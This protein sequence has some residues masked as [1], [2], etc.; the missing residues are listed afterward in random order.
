MV[1]LDKFL[2]N[3]K[4]KA[5]VIIISGNNKYQFKHIQFVVL[6]LLW[7]LLSINCS[8]YLISRMGLRWK[9]QWLTQ[10]KF[11]N[12]L[13]SFFSIFWLYHLVF[14]SFLFSIT[15]I[16]DIEVKP[17]SNALHLTIEASAITSWLICRN[18][19]AVGSNTC[20]NL[21]SWV[22]FSFISF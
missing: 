1:V 19:L 13:C 16:F 14:L 18:I 9:T 17:F 4:L 5:N 20:L 8:K 6:C 12:V 10:I 15:F 2:E 21:N 11:G 22:L 3:D 7:I